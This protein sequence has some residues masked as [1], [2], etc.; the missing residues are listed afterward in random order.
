[1]AAK[2]ATQ[3]KRSPGATP[4]ELMTPEEHARQSIDA[5]EHL[6]PHVRQQRRLLANQAQAAAVADAFQAGRPVNAQAADSNNLVAPARYTKQNERYVPATVPESAKQS[7]QKLDAIVARQQAG[8]TLSDGDRSAA[9]ALRKNLDVARA[10][11]P[12]TPA[13]PATEAS[14]PPAPATPETVTDVPAKASEA[15][16]APSQPEAEPAA[17]ATTTPRQPTTDQGKRAARTIDTL[18]AQRAAANG[19]LSPADLGN[20]AAARAALDIDLNRQ[21]LGANPRPTTAEGVDASDRLDELNR[22]RHAGAQLSKGQH[23]EMK[24][25]QAVLESDFTRQRLALEANGGKAPTPAENAPAPTASKAP[26]RRAPLPSARPRS[27]AA[28]SVPSAPTRPSRKP[29]N[30]GKPTASRKTRSPS[31]RPRG[32]R[33]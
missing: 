6:K 29:C 25:L 26:A 12:A 17:P 4:P 32:S 31:R 30:N 13:T 9:H 15:P 10:L 16:A 27:C 11:A 8:A 14:A 18:S 21:V 23:A 22:A 1:M 3:A 2:A 19:F 28:R 24:S 33:R 7:G 5:F 20:L